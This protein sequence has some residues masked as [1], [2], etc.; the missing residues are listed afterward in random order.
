MLCHRFPRHAAPR[1]IRF[2]LAVLFPA[3]LY[4]QGVIAGEETAVVVAQDNLP[5]LPIIR[6]S[7]EAPV[8]ELKT[9]LDRVVGADFRIIDAAPSTAGLYVGLDS[10]FPWLTLADTKALGPEG[11]LLQT[12]GGSVYLIGHGPLGVQH[13]VTT[14]L[15]RLGCRWFF[16]G[17]AWECVPQRATIAGIWNERRRPS[18]PTQRRIWYGYGAYE[19]CRQDLEQWYR[20]NRLGGPLPIHIGHTWHGLKPQVE[21]E[22]HPEWFALVD[23][24]R[25]P[26][27]P[28]YSH[29]EVI[30]RAIQSALAA[31]E[32]GEKVITMTPPDGLGFCE[33]ERCRSVAGVVEVFED[34]GSLFGRRSS[35][36]LVNVTSETVF[37]MVNRV[38][39][40]VAERHPDVLTGCYAYSAYSHP[41]SFE[42]H[43]N[44]YVQTT[45]A[46]RRTPLSLAEQLSALGKVSSQLGVREYYSVYQWD[47]DY[48]HAGKL[49]PA[50]LRTGLRFFHDRGVT[51]VNAEASNNWA[52]RGLGYYLASQLMWD[53]DANVESLVRDFYIRA[54]GP[55][56]KV[57]ERYY[58][59]WYGSDVGVLNP[60]A[61]LP[62]RRRFNDEG[63][64]NLETLKRAYR[65]VDEAMRLVRDQ[66]H[67]RDRVDHLRMYLH[68][69]LLRTGVESAAAAG[70]R[71]EILKAIGRETV[72]GGRLTYT[73]MIHSRP[74]LG[75]A[76]LRRFRDFEDL[77]TDLSETNEWRRIGLPPDHAELNR[78]WSQD[79]A[80]LGIY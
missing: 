78:I 26:T 32:R 40:A 74:L 72:F 33:C 69:L 37:R 75:K 9:Y 36:E 19:P 15:Q 54:F 20:H 79:R 34:Y 39:A 35:A 17:D 47:W 42:L 57:M 65:D 2:A 80:Q 41:P 12:R 49:T 62:A 76:F 73:N 30:E 24:Q 44:A 51:A 8:V 18:F 3:L 77:L 70:D 43:P 68:Y 22:E 71:Q 4:G 50:Q 28:C 14:Y 52:A 29:P 63:R 31:A 11:V 66:P 13:A 53:I 38:A 1:G 67:Y 5:R 48:P 55:A 56:A 6:G 59:R 61:E 7:V 16:P 10:D 64:H 46:Y 21:F 23:G 58:V 27:K 25:Q 60:T 45:T